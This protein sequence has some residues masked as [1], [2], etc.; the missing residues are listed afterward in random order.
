MTARII[1]VGTAAPTYDAPQSEAA[2]LHVDLE[3]PSRNRAGRGTGF[4]V[5]LLL[6]LFGYL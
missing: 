3:G 5:A 1:G 2:E 6:R 4:G